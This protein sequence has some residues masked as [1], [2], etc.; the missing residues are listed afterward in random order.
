MSLDLLREKGTPLEAQRFDWRALDPA[1]FSKLDD[2]AFTRVRALLARG[3]ERGSA[4][5]QHAFARADDGFRGVLAEVRRI[6]HHQRTALGALLP[7]DQTPLET[8]IGHQQAA[9]EVTASAARD[10]RDP[11]VARALRLGLVEHVDHL[12]RC[13]ALLDRLEGKDAN[14]ILQCATDVVPGRP[15]PE[16]HRHP[17]ADVAEPYGPDARLAT[18]LHALALLH[19]EEASLDFLLT[20]APTYA[21]PVARELLAE[22]ASVEEQHVTRYGSLVPARETWLERWLLHE[23]TEVWLYFACVKQEPNRRVKALF[24]RFLAQELGHLQVVLDLF[25]RHD[26]R[27]PLEVIPATL[28]E[29]LDFASHRDQVRDVLKLEAEARAP[30]DA[31]S[32]AYRD[33]LAAKGSPSRA[34]SAGYRWTPISELARRTPT[35]QP[36]RRAA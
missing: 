1:P 15:T 3:I 29:P 20:V 33:A 36:R 17:L 34:V 19:A 8:L 9:I 11:A 6:E 5:F 22:L 10:E 26:A 25:R 32:I 18:K 12:Y 16:Q 24:E 28:P 31:R 13:S 30:A 21:D 35:P 14:T 7:P 27:D 2:D 4:L 23:A